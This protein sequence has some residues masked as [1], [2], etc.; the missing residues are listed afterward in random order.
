MSL[1]GVSPL[2]PAYADQAVAGVRDIAAKPLDG[3]DR[4][5]IHK[6]N[7]AIEK[8]WDDVFRQVIP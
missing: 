5:P 8:D 2:F 6:V 7:G 3:V 1:G 4:L